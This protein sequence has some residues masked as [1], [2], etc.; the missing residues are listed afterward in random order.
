[1]VPYNH[2]QVVHRATG[3]PLATA[4]AGRRETVFDA[5]SRSQVPIRN[6]CGGSAICG[7]C[8]VL[9]EDGAEDLRPPTGYERQLLQD[10]GAHEPN[11]RLA[12][13][14]RLPPERKRLVVALEPE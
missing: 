13:C 8:V 5:L 3:E 4:P 2:Y 14:I 6:Q 7:Q 9:V 1:M 12:C 10:I 11:A